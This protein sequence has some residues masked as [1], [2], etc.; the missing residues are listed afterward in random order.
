[1]NRRG[2]T[3][4]E[5]LVVIGVIAL[6][7]S[8]LLP[9][10]R[11]AREAGRTTA[12][13]SNQRQLGIGWAAYANDYKERVMPLAYWEESDIGGGPVVYWWG[14]GGEPGVDVDHARGFLAP[15]VGVVLSARSVYECP[16]QAW[17][18]Y[19]AQ[20]GANGPTST[21]G[22]NGYYLSPS[23]T[24]G[25]GGTIGRRAWKR[26]H[27]IERPESLL[28]FADTMLAM[29]PVRNCALL[30]PPLLW[31]GTSWSTNPSPTTSFR[32]E[33]GRNGIGVSAGARA[34][35]GVRGVRAKPEW[36]THP[37]ASIGSVGV[38]N[39]PHYVPDAASWR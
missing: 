9:G 27:E 37:T 21:Y 3:L 39:D 6:L 20:G 2:F 16:A 7:L 22:Y 14:A 11:G 18:S 28:I 23:K 31:D 5:L 29:S 25:W 38:A 12:C 34:D 19:R 32:H 35:G 15:Y 13:L 36:L 24:P 26:M 1:M 33:R 4:I 10:L 30:D 17:G 8:L